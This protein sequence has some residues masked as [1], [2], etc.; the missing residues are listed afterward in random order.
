M[1]FLS[2][3]SSAIYSIFCKVTGTGGTV[4]ISSTSSVKKG[5]KHLIVRFDSNI[6]PELKWKFYPKQK[7]VE[8]MTGENN[9]V[10][11]ETLNESDKS[12]IGT[13]V[14]NVTPQKAGK[15]FNKIECFCFREQLLSPHERILMPVSFFIDTGFD[16]DPEM[17]DIKEI[18]LSYT[19][20]KIREIK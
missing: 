1:L 3:S 4:S 12:T 20:F 19:F 17:K 9:L 18:T 2:F 14:Y 10:F 8:I 15:Y 13:A 7:S 16:T 6:E 11:Y 5:N